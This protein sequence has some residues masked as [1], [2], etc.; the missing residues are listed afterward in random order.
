[1]R[2]FQP[3]PPQRPDHRG[4]AVGAGVVTAL[5]IGLIWVQEIAD[6]LLLGVN[7]DRLGIYPR[8]L[9]TWWHIFTAP[10]LHGG[11]EHLIANTL[12]LATLAF[13]SAVRSVG[14]FLTATLIIMVVGG[15]LIW[16]L[17]RGGSA[18]LGASILIFGYFAYLLGVGWW[19]RT[20]AA[21]GVATIA[22]VLYGSILWGVLPTDPRV[23]F[24]GHLFG[25]IGG[26][27]AAAMLHRQRP[28]GR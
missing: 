13:M 8:N 14:R 17:A 9:A 21:I 2:D 25:F 3:A 15:G 23:S 28:G 10:Y 19:E 1:M 18:H 24:E 26:L 12:P 6:Q 16:L 22:A 5:L 11:W 27:V 20:P 4:N 7:L